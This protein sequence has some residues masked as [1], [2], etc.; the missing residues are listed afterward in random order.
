MRT[1]LGQ[2]ALQQ[3]NALVKS[4]HLLRVYEL[5]L[6]AR[7]FVLIRS[8]RIAVPAI[9]MLI[10][11]IAHD[12]DTASLQ[13]FAPDDTARE[14]YLEHCVFGFGEECLQLDCFR[15]S[16]GFGEPACFYSIPDKQDVLELFMLFAS[17]I[18]GSASCMVLL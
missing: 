11:Q 13:F 4:L 14:E 16:V 3:Q 12:I 1:W 18:I 7:S 6:T 9:S 15:E 8:G 17:T 5:L 2:N 10:D